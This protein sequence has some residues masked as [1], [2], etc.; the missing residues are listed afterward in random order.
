ML[1]RV[2]L[3]FMILVMSFR[4]FKS[5]VVAKFVKSVVELRGMFKFCSGWCQL[6]CKDHMWPHH[7]FYCI[8]ITTLPILLC[9]SCEIAIHNNCFFVCQSACFAVIASELWIDLRLAGCCS[10]DHW[11]HVTAFI[12]LQTLQTDLLWCHKGLLA[13]TTFI[14]LPIDCGHETAFV[15]SDSV[16]TINFV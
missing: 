16:K 3:D 8:C 2:S 4:L 15:W 10:S 7:L 12:I 9:H 11:I 13:K 1:S 5:D 6:F 14:I